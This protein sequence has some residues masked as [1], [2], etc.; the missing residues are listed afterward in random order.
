MSE[1]LLGLKLDSQLGL[2]LLKC[3]LGWA[4]LVLWMAPVFMNM[5]DVIVFV[6]KNNTLCWS[7]ALEINDNVSQKLLLYTH[8]RRS[9]G[10]ARCN[11]R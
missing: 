10:W 7:R 11:W 1:H 9:I 2:E 6:V 4:L 8:L 3:Q 5:N